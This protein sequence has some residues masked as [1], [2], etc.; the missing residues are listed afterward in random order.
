MPKKSSDDLARPD[1]PSQTTKEGLRIPVP[2]KDELFGVLN[3]TIR[4]QPAEPSARSD[5]GKRRPSQD[6]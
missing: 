4:K 5:R 6:Q 2:T 1:E 3:R